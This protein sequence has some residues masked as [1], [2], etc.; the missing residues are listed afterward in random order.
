MNSKKKHYA[1]SL[2]NEEKTQYKIITSSVINL[3]MVVKKLR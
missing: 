2:I 1:K 3:L